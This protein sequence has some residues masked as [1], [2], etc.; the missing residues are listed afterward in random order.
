MKSRAKLKTND[1]MLFMRLLN[2]Y[3]KCD[4]HELTFIS[5]TIVSIETH[6]SQTFLIN[7]FETLIESSISAEASAATPK[8]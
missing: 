7:V 5:T 1:W 2:M 3:F 6:L 4:S 8:A